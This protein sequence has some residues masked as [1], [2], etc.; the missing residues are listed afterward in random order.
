M[1]TLP[2]LNDDRRAVAA[3]SVR[4]AALAILLMLTAQV[5][6]GTAVSLYTDFGPQGEALGHALTHAGA[7]F[8]AH[9]VIALLIVVRSLQA[10][11]RGRGVGHRLITAATATG[12]LAVV[13]AFAAGMAFVGRPDTWL[14][15]AMSLLTAVAIV[16]YVGCLRLLREVHPAPTIERR[17]EP[18]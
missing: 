11:V 16:S 2:P 9:V 18:L 10:L 8:D 17:P 1:S 7:V 14:S 4:R 12:S 13:G 5:G 6:I 15:L 3:T